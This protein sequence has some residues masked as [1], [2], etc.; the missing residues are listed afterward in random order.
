[1]SKKLQTIFGAHPINHG[2]MNILPRQ[3]HCG[4]FLLLFAFFI[5]FV[6]F[7]A[8]AQ[9]SAV[10]GTVV[11]EKG[12]QMPGVTVGVKGTTVVQVTDTKGHFIIKLP[13]GNTVLSFSFIGYVKQEINAGAQS[14]LKV[15]LVPD[16]KNLSEVVV[17]GY[18][19]QKKSDVTGA[20]SS[21]SSKDFKDQPVTRIDQALQGRVAGVQVVSNS[22][23]PG[24]DVS[25]RVR[26]SNSI[27]GD[28][29]PLY[30]IDGFIGGDFNNLNPDDIANIEVLKDAS[31][32]A[33]YGSRGANG[34]VLVTT[35][36]GNSQKQEITLT[37]IFY[38]SRPLKKF[39][40]LNAA[41]F[42]TT[43]NERNAAVGIAPSFTPAQ[44]D[45][46]RAKGGT[47]W[48]DEVFRNGAGQE[49]K[50]AYSGGSAK[51]S[52][53]MS[54]DYLNQDGIVINSNYKRYAI[55]SN[56]NTTFSDKLSTRL[57]ISA[58]R[59][60]SLNISNQG[61]NGSVAQALAWAPTTS[62]RDASGQ[63][64]KVD[65]T[66]SIYNNPVALANDKKNVLDNSNITLNGGANYH[67]FKDLSLDVSFGV[68]YQN[69]QGKNY[70]GPSITNNI[71]NASRTST[72]L[73][74]LQNTN[75]LNYSHV[76]N[77]VHS[78]NV[79]AVFEQQKYTSTGFS[80]NAN[81]L[82]FSN[83]GYD[84]LALSTTQSA[85]ASYSGSALISY[86]GRVN[87]SY[88]DKYLL[89]VS[90]RRDGSSKFQ[91][92]N[93]ESTFPS[94]ALGWKLSEE[95]FIKRLNIFDQFKLRGSWGL[96]GSQAINPY[97]TLS[98]YLNDAFSAANSFNNTTVNSGIVLGNAANPNLKWETT[99]A[100]DLGLDISLFNNRLNFTAD[101]YLKNTKDLLLSLPL[102]GYAGGG[103]I[104]SNV[105]KMKNSGLEFNLGGTPVQSGKFSWSSSFNITFQKNLVKS[106]GTL[107]S[108][109]SDKT[110]ANAGG[111]LSTQPEFIIKPGYALGS[112]WGL[113]Y[114]GTWK[115]S[116]AAEA[117]KFGNK[118]G[119]SKYQDMDGDNAIT[120]SDFQI[121]GNGT[122]KQSLGWNNTFNYGDFSLNIFIQ[123]L[124]GFKKLDYSY[125]SSITANANAKQATNV[126]IKNRYIPGSNETSDIP[127]FSTTNKDY[128]ESSRFLENG[129]FVRVKN[130]SFSYHLPQGMIKNVDLKFFIGA[131]NLFTITKYKGF[132]PESTNAG[133]GSDINQGIDF[134]SYPNSK[135]FNA[136]L[137]LKFQ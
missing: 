119:D 106:L 23:A 88:K 128:F 99:R 101:A 32:T 34:V 89:T 125:A 24:G 122:P 98:T 95:P 129:N 30:V 113:K 79:T 21:L 35:K 131:T 86:L 8:R 65:P 108:V 64:T 91:P 44:I 115:P 7:V 31:S 69:L 60:E 43:V 2:G 16:N 136:G 74:N 127:A 29:N 77:N 36:K 87:Y 61:I 112:Y 53:F 118:P 51:T 33:I 22:G 92:T 116:E 135:T 73:L 45:N 59:R 40:L 62:I 103:S 134:G 78:L 76:F 5:A 27:L 72:E 10:S 66:G 82:T 126:G 105:G 1:M 41:D 12:L 96:T 47:D 68:D 100:E 54:G 56:I 37:P 90:V 20:L 4:R 28:N 38:S 93:Q 81:S 97:A 132:D 102:P 117:A 15:T 3:R 6:P 58:I 55:R 49:Y 18:G 46:F 104:I 137:I 83:L 50:L 109:F 52:F 39:D 25:I 84:N 70:S 11:D 42:A 9:G 123:S 48:Q 130:L 121:I 63:Y 111:G 85:G 26:G 114:L 124:L 19:T 94:V 17:V 67:F 57:N 120:G 110:V 133:S 107:A 13:P 80:A 14:E 71:P 75:T